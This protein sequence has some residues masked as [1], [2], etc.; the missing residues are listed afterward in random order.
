MSAASLADRLDQLIVDVGPIPVSV[1][2][3]AALY[4]DA[5]GFYTAGGGRAGRRG[6]FITSPEVGPLFGHVIARAVDD[7]WRDLG[8]PAT[9]VVEEWGA[10]PGTL[11]RAVV[12]AD[13][14]VLR[15]GAL[16]WHMIERSG[17]QRASHPDHS[18]L[19]SS[20]RAGGDPITGAV[21]AN[22][23][24]DNLPF[25]IAERT[26]DGW[27]ALL[28]DGRDASGR[29][30]L[31][32]DPASAGEL[33]QLPDLPVGSRVPVVEAARRWLDDVLGCLERGRVVVFDYGAETAELA[34]RGGGWL[35]THVDHD[36]Q[37]D[38]LTDPGS[39]DITTD[40]AFDQLTDESPA[41]VDVGQAEWLRRH[42]IDVLVDEGRR[43]W[44]ES[45]AIGDL[46]ALKARSRVREADALLDP[47]G[48][49]GFRVLEWSVD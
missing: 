40:V 1:Y 20:A 45:A 4:D 34:T 29:F 8:E 32:V 14:E 13:P 2:V 38:W 3:E 23:L 17:A 7:W 11:A 42:G 12:D 46:R 5:A 44:E 49:G 30:R 10:G 9:F 16:S 35:R 39:C 33:D 41:R 22:E 43:I 36:G 15:A 18:A 47:T 37:A 28:V 26:A 31:V 48:L 27:R 24:L 19:V 6:D 25:D 21:L